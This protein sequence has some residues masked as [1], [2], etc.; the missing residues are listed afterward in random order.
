METNTGTQSVYVGNKRVVPVCATLF[1]AG[2]VTPNKKTP[3]QP[4]M[5]STAQL[6][7]GEFGKKC[8]LYEV[9]DIAKT[10]TEKEITT[11]YRKLAL[12]FVSMRFSSHFTDG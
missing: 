7:Y 4:K 1:L 3:K 11:A 12:R 10:A 6:I 9:F 8:D 5:S 2:R